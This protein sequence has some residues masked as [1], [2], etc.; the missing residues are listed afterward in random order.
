M[1][2]THPG[3][4]FSFDPAARYMYVEQAVHEPDPGIVT[5]RHA[6]GVT[7]VIAPVRLFLFGLGVIMSKMNWTKISARSLIPIA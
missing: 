7:G 2:L 4:N 3:H 5:S 6:Q 1:P